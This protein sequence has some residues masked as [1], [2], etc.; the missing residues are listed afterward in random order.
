MI[1]PREEKRD[2]LLQALLQEYANASQLYTNTIA[3]TYT[4]FFGFL[5]VHGALIVVFFLA[6]EW[7]LLVSILG[8]ILAIFTYLTI[9]HVWQF[10]KFRI[11]QAK[12]IENQINDELSKANIETKLTT[13]DRHM[14]LFG[15]NKKIKKQEI[16]FPHL[17]EDKYLPKGRCGAWLINYFP[18]QADRVT[19]VI[20]IIFWI[21]LGI[22]AWFLN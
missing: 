9:E 5:A 14:S 6:A 3:V 2:T 15:K 12:E 13:F 20:L 7:R 10:T 18:H 8:F 17:L 21:V 22:F 1:Q 16:E 11:A 4:R 19:T